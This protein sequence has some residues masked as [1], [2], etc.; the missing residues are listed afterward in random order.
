MTPHSK[1]IKT[2]EYY[3]KR[4]GIKTFSTGA[5]II[6]PKIDY[7]VSEGWSHFSYYNLANYRSIHAEL[8]AI[9]RNNYRKTLRGTTCYICTIRNKSGNIGLAKPCE[10]CMACLYEVGVKTVVFTIGGTAANRY[11]FEVIELV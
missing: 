11:E 5:V 10:H 9:L 7:Q 4:S 1:H 8:H 2:A 6:L 3:A